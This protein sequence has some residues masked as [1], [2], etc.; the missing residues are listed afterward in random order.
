MNIV[1]VA[2]KQHQA[3]LSLMDNEMWQDIATFDLKC[4]PNLTKSTLPRN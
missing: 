4:E 2:S 3:E 1:N